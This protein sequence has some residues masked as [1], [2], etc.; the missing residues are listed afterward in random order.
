MRSP[1]GLGSRCRPRPSATLPPRPEGRGV[2]GRER[3]C[4]LL[5]SGRVIRSASPTGSGGVPGRRDPRAATS[6]SPRALSLRLEVGRPR[7]RLVIWALSLGRGSR[8]S[9]SVGCRSGPGCGGAAQKGAWGRAS[10]QGPTVARVGRGLSRARRPSRDGQGVRDPPLG[11][12]SAPG[13]RARPPQRLPTLGPVNA[14]PRPLGVPL[15]VQVAAR[16]ELPRPRD[17]RQGGPPLKR[18]VEERA[19]VRL[20]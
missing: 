10:A 12:A 8:G 16:Y 4:G 5:G 7:L 13:R 18:H 6:G 20:A 15:L 9:K 14:R 17:N 1:S 11:L 19:S 2:R 3:V